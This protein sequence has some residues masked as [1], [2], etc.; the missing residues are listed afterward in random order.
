MTICKLLAAVILVDQILSEILNSY[1]YTWWFCKFI[2]F[3]FQLQWLVS[4]W[5]N[6]QW[7]NE[8]IHNEQIPNC[9]KD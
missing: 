3:S 1:V 9:E 2:N 4:E 7:V 6:S 8:W 5:M